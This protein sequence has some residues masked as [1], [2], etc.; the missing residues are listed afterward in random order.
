MKAVVA[1]VGLLLLPCDPAQATTGDI[2]LT[3]PKP[4]SS[5]TS[6]VDIRWSIEG[7][8]DPDV[9]VIVDNAQVDY[10]YSGSFDQNRSYWDSAH[11]PGQ[12]TVKVVTDASYGPSRSDSVTFTVPAPPPS[13]ALT[14]DGTTHTKDY[15][16]YADAST[17]Y[18]AARDASLATL[19]ICVDGSRACI[20]RNR[21]VQHT[22]LTSRE[23]PPPSRQP[24]EHTFTA[25]V[26]DTYGARATSTLRVRVVADPPPESK[27]T[28]SGEPAARGESAPASG[29]E[30]ENQH[31]TASVATDDERISADPIGDGSTGFPI[32]ELPPLLPADA[33]SSS[34]ED[35]LSSPSVGPS[36]Q[37]PSVAAP[38]AQERTGALRRRARRPAPR[39]AHDI[40]AS[41]SWA[42]GPARAAARRFSQ[43]APAPVPPS[44]APS[45]SHRATTCG[46][47][48]S[49]EPGRCLPPGPASG[50]PGRRRTADRRA[51]RCVRAFGP[52]GRSWIV[53]QRAPGHRSCA[54]AVRGEVLDRCGTGAAQVARARGRRPPPLPQPLSGAVRRRRPAGTPPYLVME[55]VDGRRLSEFLA[56]GNGLNERAFGVVALGL[57]GALRAMHQA[58]VQHNDVKPDNVIL[59]AGSPVLV[60]F[61]GAVLAGEPA[62]QVLITRGYA[63]PERMH[64]ERGSAAS[65]VWSWGAVM[66]ACAP[67]ATGVPPRWRPLVTAALSLDPRSRPTPDDILRSSSYGNGAVLSDRTL[68]AT[69]LAPTALLT[70]ATTQI[71]GGRHD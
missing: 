44:A 2:H 18:E 57:A 3:A 55:W 52:R 68:L 17:A 24:G 35:P 8:G 58:S 4:G 56:E 20:S 49:L 30:S 71:N 43:A 41:G 6:M 45:R 25:T 34:A 31:F 59:R 53:R 21:P 9:Q 29:T 69:S 22:E 11:Q 66:R 14:S 38:E 16:L 48:C 39:A 26:V 36:A 7:G 12:H 37:S 67:V 50:D 65:D 42:A 51:S 54:T 40:H 32:P 1:A 27:A 63:A 46:A 47:A 33:P 23:L 5:Q 61:G 13:L 10:Y 28:D 70:C 15:V 19:T 62:S 64:G 60:D